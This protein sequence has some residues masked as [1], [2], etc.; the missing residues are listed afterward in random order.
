[1]A[2]Q[3]NIQQ[4]FADLEERLNERFDKLEERQLGHAIARAELEGRVE[5]LEEKAGWIGAGIG[6]SLM[7]VC[8]LAV[9]AIRHKL[10]F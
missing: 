8:G 4:A 1:M 6:A 2:P 3:W 10:G 7:G 9:I 5:N